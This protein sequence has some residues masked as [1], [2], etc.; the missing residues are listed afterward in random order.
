MATIQLLD[1]QTINQIAAGEVIEHPA[2][3]VKELIENSLDAGATKIFV[4]VQVGGQQ[5]ICIRDNG[6]GM[7]EEDV[8]KSLLRHA[9]SKIRTHEDLTT[10]TTMGFRGE[11]LS[12]IA[13]ISEISIRTA[14][15][16]G[17]KALETGVSLI[18]HGGVVSS[19]QSTTCLPGTTIEVKNLFYNVPARKKFQKS[20]AKDSFEITKLVT[21][22][23]IG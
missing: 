18:A 4:E 19:L 22:L 6:S 9:T 2:S 17:S 7:S 23:A 3:V 12:S 13:S 8:K 14:Q 20:P 16:T 15:H 10:L 5:L 1:E 21:Q 11:A